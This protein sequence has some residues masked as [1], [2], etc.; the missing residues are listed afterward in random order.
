MTGNE[1]R[2]RERLRQLAETAGSLAPRNM[3]RAAERETPPDPRPWS[4]ASRAE[5]F[6][7]VMIVFGLVGS[8]VGLGVL[9]SARGYG[10]VVAIFC[11]AVI[12][13]VARARVDNR[14]HWRTRR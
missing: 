13:T 6:A 5:R 3:A 9:M 14:R 4:R 11:L 2:E 8:V 10:L 12:A 7:V 1:S